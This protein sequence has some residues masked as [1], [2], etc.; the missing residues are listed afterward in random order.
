V[1]LCGVAGSVVVVIGGGSVVV[2]VGSVVDVGGSV[3][4]VVGCCVAWSVVDELTGG[5][6]GA[7]ETVVRP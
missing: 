1:S 6:C 7:V 4:V 3:V 2:V 5:I